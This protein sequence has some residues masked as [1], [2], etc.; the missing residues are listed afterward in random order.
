MLIVT[1]AVSLAS[2]I[3]IRPARKAGIANPEAGEPPC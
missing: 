2:A 1:M 3:A